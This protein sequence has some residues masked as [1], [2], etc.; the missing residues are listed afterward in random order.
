M[1]LKR[2]ATKEEKISS[3]FERNSFIDIKNCYLQF[4]SLG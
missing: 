2:R 1:D 4:S 3:K